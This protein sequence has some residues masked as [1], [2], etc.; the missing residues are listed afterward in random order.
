MS[1]QCSITNPNECT[2]CGPS[3]AKGDI[4]LFNR[5]GKPRI[6]TVVG[7]GPKYITI[8]VVGMATKTKVDRQELTLSLSTSNVFI[9]SEINL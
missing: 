8:E 5:N 4:I 3:V 9:S 7:L 6:G 2:T 1:E